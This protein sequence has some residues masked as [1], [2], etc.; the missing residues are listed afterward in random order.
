MFAC[1][2]VSRSDYGISIYVTVIEEGTFSISIESLISFPYHI[3]QMDETGTFKREIIKLRLLP[4]DINKANK[5]KNQ[6][7]FK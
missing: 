7:S 6:I 5:Q 1:V 4:P 2:C 3:M